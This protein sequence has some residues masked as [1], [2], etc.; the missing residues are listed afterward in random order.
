MIQ[1]ERSIERFYRSF[2][3]RD[4]LGMAQE[5]HR[6][7]FFYDP[8]F[9]PLRGPEVAAMWEMLLTG[10]NELDLRFGEVTAETGYGSCH[11][12]ASYIFTAT[13]RRVENR[14]LARFAFQDGKIIEHQDEWSFRRWC[15]QALGWKG[16]LFGW[17]TWLQGKVQRQARRRLDKFIERRGGG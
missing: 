15:A 2:Q 9:G 1:E 5:Y 10:A 16:M 17:T 6:D 7:I 3:Q 14:G 4:W 8:V 12:V 13:G 11:W